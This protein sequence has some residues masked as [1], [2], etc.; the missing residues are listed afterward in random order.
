MIFAG[1][2]LVVAPVDATAEPGRKLP[3]GRADLLEAGPPAPRP[4]HHNPVGSR[5]EFVAERSK[6]FPHEPFYP[7]A[8]HCVPEATR[9]RNAEP[10]CGLLI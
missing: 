8:L 1:G 4:G 10:R 9:C 5:R 7:I 3:Q 2:V 6:R